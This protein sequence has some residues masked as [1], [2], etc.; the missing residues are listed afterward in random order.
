MRNRVVPCRLLIRFDGGALFGKFAARRRQ[1]GRTALRRAALHVLAGLAAMSSQA[2][3]DA[4]VVDGNAAL[5][6]VVS[7]NVARSEVVAAI[8]R[9]LDIP[10]SGTPVANGVLSGRFSG[11]LS[12]ILK[13]VLSENGFVIAFNNG[14]PSRIVVTGKGS[15]VP[16]PGME[17]MEPPPM[18]PP[19]IE[20]L[21][22]EFM[23]PIDPATGVVEP[24]L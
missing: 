12:H 8:S 5:L 7:D 10:V 2:A 23:P 17:F 14:L 20:P 24:E 1:I 3:A 13:A 16:Q 18:E 11:D 19:P 15:G 6:T 21:P 22:P 4:L 9:R